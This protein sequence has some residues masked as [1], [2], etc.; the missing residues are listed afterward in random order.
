MNIKCPNISLQHVLKL[1]LKSS[2]IGYLECLL[3]SKLRGSGDLLDESSSNVSPSGSIS[4]VPSCMPFSWFG[5]RE[6]GK[7]K[8]REK[9]RSA[10]SCSL[11]RTPSEGYMEDRTNTVSRDQMMRRF[12]V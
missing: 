8:E 4:S 2:D 11:P 9:E 12:F 1:S 10:S 7:E 6:K 3:L 5:D